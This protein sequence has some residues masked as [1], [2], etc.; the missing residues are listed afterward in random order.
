MRKT[1]TLL[2]VLT[3]TSSFS[4]LAD[5]PNWRYVEGGYTKIDFDNNESFE[6]D[7]LTVNSKYLLNNNWFLNGE[8]SFFEEGNFDFDMLTVGAGY[9]LPVNATTDAYF[10]ANL[11][12]VDGDVEDD[13][14]YSIN[15]GLR[16]MITDQ[17]ELAGEVGYYDIDEGEATIKVGAN[18]YITP[19]WAVGASYEMIDDLD[20]MQVTARYAF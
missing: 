1:I 20:I 18:Y 14:G 9:R 5:S 13:T 11:E 4:V 15:A 12:R 17:V 2:A 7:G 19:Q 8:Y 10:G 6:P 16:S 3:A